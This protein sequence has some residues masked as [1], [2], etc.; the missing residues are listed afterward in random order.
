[1]APDESWL[2]GS[3]DRVVRIEVVLGYRVGIW[4]DSLYRV[5]VVEIPPLQ[6]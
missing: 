2:V 6:V 1:V 3:F 4:D 5:V